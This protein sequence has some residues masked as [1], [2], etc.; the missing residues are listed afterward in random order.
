MAFV[1]STVQVIIAIALVIILCVIAF[2]VYNTEMIKAIK[3]SGQVRRQVVIFSGIK[4]LKTSNNE[5]YTTID[6][7]D[8]MYRNIDSSVNQ[9][10]GAEYTYN[11]WLYMNPN[12]SSGSY[13]TIRDQNLTDVGL[14]KSMSNLAFDNTK[15]FVLFVRGENNAVAYKNTCGN[16]KMDVLVKQPLIKFEQN[17]NV[18]TIELNTQ[19]K[20]D[21][22]QEKA[23]NTC[24]SSESSWLELNK[25]RIGVQN[26]K[27]QLAGKWN[28]ITLVVQDTYPGDPLPMRNKV[29]IRLYINGTME[30]DR[31]LD[32]KLSEISS[33]ATL[34]R[35]NNGSLFVAPT[36]KANISGDNTSGTLTS[37]TVDPTTLNTNQLLMADLSYY[38]YAIDGSVIKS[39]FG[40]GFSKKYAPSMTRNTNTVN[41][42]FDASI[43]DE[44]STPLTKPL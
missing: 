23:R 3:E 44:T 2:S 4:D 13:S 12:I 25:Y 28:M 29:R 34:L 22:M 24:N 6:P 10:A 18:M 39:L 14:T 17:Y 15:P 11:F 27:Q 38:N 32:G 26:V 5:E 20:P 37:L 9:K 30:L 16:M 19:D 36:I 7:T 41:S 31:Y 33:K 42:V 40:A 1:G 21:A 35:P 8:A 43:G